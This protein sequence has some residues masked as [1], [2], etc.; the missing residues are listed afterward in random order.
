MSRRQ[1]LIP[2]TEPLSREAWRSVCR[3]ARRSTWLAQLVSH[4][5]GRSPEGTWRGDWLAFL[6]CDRDPGLL[7]FLDLDERLLERFSDSGA[8][9]EIGDV[10]D[11]TA[12]FFAV[13]GLDVV[14]LQ[15][16][17]PIRR[18]PR[19]HSVTDPTYGPSRLSRA[20]CLRATTQSPPAISTNPTASGHPNRSLRNTAASPADANG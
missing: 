14:V 13:E 16:P 10:G 9:F 7:R 2:P 4:R 17:S 6:P 8:G 20:V 15:D 5:F 1:D 11:E 19:P 12:V 3:M 18:F